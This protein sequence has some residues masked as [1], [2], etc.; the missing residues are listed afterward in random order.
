[1][2]ELTRY[3]RWMTVFIM[4]FLMICF[5][6]AAFLPRVETIALGLALGTVISWI[7]A[8]YLGRKVRRMLDG[9][10]EGNLKRVNLGFL[11]R[12]ALAV[13]AVFVAMQ[14]P[15]YFNL[16][17]V[18]VGLVIAQFSLLFIGILLSRKADS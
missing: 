5:L 2:S 7:N 18:V 11:T 6:A 12:A 17:A 3:R 16:Y 14:Y 1:M 15:Q 8:S 13:L 4:Y 10:A 9:A